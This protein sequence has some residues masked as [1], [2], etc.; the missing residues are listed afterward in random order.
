[1]K[2]SQNQPSEK[3]FLECVVKNE[4]SG[5]RLDNFLSSRFT[6]Y[7]RE[8]WKQMI[9]TG[10]VSVNGKFVKP[11]YIIKTDDLLKFR[12][13]ENEE[14]NTN[15]KFDIIFEDDDYMV[16][17]KPANLPVHPAG[18][19]RT[20]TLLNFLEEK[21]KV[22]TVN[23]IDRETSG[24]VVFAKNPEMASKLGNLFYQKKV[25]KQYIV[26]VHGSFPDEMSMKGWIGKHDSS[27]I[28]K[29]QKVYLDKNYDEKNGFAYCETAF[30]K[31]AEKN[32]ISKLYAFPV[33]GR[34]HQIR[35][36]LDSAGFPVV[37]DKMYGT[38]DNRFF[39][40]VKHGYCEEI[41]DVIIRQALHCYH[42]SF[43][44]PDSGEKMD[45]FADEPSDMQGIL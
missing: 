5:R 10:L 19:Y 11:S 20:K 28:I 24:I 35:A 18:I 30:T 27:R 40:F 42:I 2:L 43:I 15:S 39:I 44:H 17:N 8:S 29:K 31:I 4:E 37:G 32:G 25:S 9:V 33:S 7:S 13:F 23:R 14:P 41:K 12:L 1:M 34:Q 21:Y 22:Y 38:D 6:Y 16:I 26:Y 36:S 3:Q 45:F